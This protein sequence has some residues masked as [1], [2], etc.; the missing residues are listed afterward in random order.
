[1][2]FKER[3][4]MN[5]CIVFIV[6]ALLGLSSMVSAMDAA[7]HE[8][9]QPQMRASLLNRFYASSCA[10]FRGL[11]NYV[12]AARTIRRGLRQF[13][14]TTGTVQEGILNAAAHT[15]LACFT[16]S[17]AQ[18]YGVNK[19]FKWSDYLFYGYDAVINGH[20]IIDENNRRCYCAYESERYYDLWQKLVKQQQ[21]AEEAE[22]EEGQ[23]HAQAAPPAQ[24]PAAAAAPQVQAPARNRAA[25]GEPRDQLGWSYVHAGMAVATI[26]GSA[27]L[28]SKV[29]A[30]AGSVGALHKAGSLLLS[31]SAKP[32]M[33]GLTTLFGLNCAAVFGSMATK[34]WLEKL[35]VNPFLK[36]FL[37]RLSCKLRGVPYRPRRVPVH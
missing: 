30:L 20:Y 6:S 4:S 10:A 24:R 19:V 27:L 11:K 36:P 21:D 26:V 2:N 22:Q 1:M 23:D 29:V 31:V 35:V 7:V 5:R 13:V 12:P 16:N 33:V 8:Q 25:H 32:G 18:I 28:F 3:L 15:A 17:K 37:I 9:A 14:P 34:Y